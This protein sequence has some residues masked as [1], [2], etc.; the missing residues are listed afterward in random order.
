LLLLVIGAIVMLVG[1]AA[2][3]GLLGWFGRLPGDLR[4]D[5]GNVKVYAPIVSMLLISLGLSIGLTIIR[6]FF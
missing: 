6:R 4:Y 3:A 2:L 5:S 1:A